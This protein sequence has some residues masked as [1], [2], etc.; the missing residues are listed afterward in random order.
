MFHNGQAENLSELFIERRI[1]FESVDVAVLSVEAL[2]SLLLSE[3]ISAQRADSLLPIILKLGSCDRD[4]LKC[5]QIEFLSEDGFS[6][7]EEHFEISTESVS[8]FAA[9]WIAHPLAPLN[10]LIISNFAEIFAEPRKKQF[11]ALSRGSQDD[12]RATEFHR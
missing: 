2:D 1:D 5:I 3:L 6:L 9:E 4:L 11:S 7:L 12:F 8:Q 10:S